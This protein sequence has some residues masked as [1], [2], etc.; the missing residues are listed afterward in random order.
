MIN[1]S[2]S[3]LFEP[4]KLDAW[5]K[6]GHA[7]VR[8]A[9]GDGMRQG[10]SVVVNKARAQMSSSFTAEKPAFIRSLRAKLFNEKP[11]RLP[12]LLIGSKIPWLGVH[13]GGVINGRM[14]IPLLPKRMGRKAFKNVVET[15]L[16]T[17]AGHFVK[18]NDG[19]VLLMA[20][21]QPE[22]GAPLARFRRAHR[23]ATGGKRVKAGT[24]IPIAVLVTSS[25]M[26]R[27]FD[28]DAI[29]E[30]HLGI[31]AAAI[32]QKLKAI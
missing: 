10:G 30:S 20:E 2:V 1:V 19:K 4:S 11:D 9:V 6:K 17:G 7:A 5:T 23:N 18:T 13:A 28:L 29:V 21:Y 27:R 26:K 3:G 24:D 16:R 32:D 31:I 25:R 14:L 22:Y 15:L 8:K 12:A